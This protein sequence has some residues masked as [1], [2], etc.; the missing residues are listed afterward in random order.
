M[1]DERGREELKGR[2]YM[3]MKEE[4]G[5]EEVKG[6]KVYREVHGVEGGRR[7]IRIKGGGRRNVC[8]EV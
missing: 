1:K 3:G 8:R 6:R 5:R 7:K 2:K 4:E